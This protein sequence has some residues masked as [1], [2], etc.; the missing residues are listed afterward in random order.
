MESSGKLDH[1]EYFRLAL[2]DERQ[3]PLL[4]AC[5]NDL[6]KSIDGKDGFA[7]LQVWRE[8]AAVNHIDEQEYQRIVGLIEKD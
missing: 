4:S 3:D 7:A 6:H 8:L 1:A 5:L 2:A